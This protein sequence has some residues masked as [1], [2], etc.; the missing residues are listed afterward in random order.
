MPNT[1]YS[2][3]QSHMF[4]D[5]WGE[6]GYVGRVADSHRFQGLDLAEVLSMTDSAFANPL[7]VDFGISKGSDNSTFYL[8]SSATYKKS[9]TFRTGGV[10]DWKIT[11]ESDEEGGAL[12]FETSASAKMKLQ[13]DGELY[14]YI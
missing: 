1:N 3:N 11:H 12:L 2:D 5:D 10:V 14:L 4:S 9:L 8:D 7:T 13:S 6:I